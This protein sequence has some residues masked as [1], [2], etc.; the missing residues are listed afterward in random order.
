M[1]GMSKVVVELK[2][3]STVASM[4][5]GISQTIRGANMNPRVPQCKNC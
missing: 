1:F 3:L 5:E 4:L 2:T